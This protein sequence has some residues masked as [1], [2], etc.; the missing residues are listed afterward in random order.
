VQ[1]KR[2]GGSIN[3]NTNTNVNGRANGN[4][5][6]LSAGGAANGTVQGSGCIR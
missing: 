3:I 2:H 5:D 4:I 6:D 1:T